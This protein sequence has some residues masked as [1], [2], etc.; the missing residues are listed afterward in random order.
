MTLSRSLYS[1]RGLLLAGGAA[2][3]AAACTSR[4]GTQAGSAGLEGREIY[5][6]S[7][8][9][10]GASPDGDTIFSIRLCQ[11]PSI[12]VAWVWASVLTPDGAFLFADNEIPWAGEAA[13]AATTEDARYF[14]SLGGM[15]IR[16]SRTGRHGA[17]TGGRME[18]EKRGPD[19]FGVT[20][21]FAPSDGFTGLLDGRSEMFGAVTATVTAAGKRYPISGPGQWHEQPQSAPRFTVPFVYSSLWGK[22]VSGTLLQSPE[23]SGAYALRPGAPPF[24]F[25]SAVFSPP[26]PARTIALGAEDG[27]QAELKMQQLHLYTLQIYGKPWIGTFVRGEFLGEPVT[28]FINNWMM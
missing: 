3:I 28:G 16:F 24:I 11:Y 23:G 9:L 1:R 5:T 13:E 6:E 18:F 25:N 15:R 7:V 27:T 14:A 17:I 2:A 10:S 26:G 12:G 22:G 20:A 19:A 21:E 8:Q 4:A